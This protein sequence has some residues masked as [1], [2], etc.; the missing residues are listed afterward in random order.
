MTTS[1][2]TYRPPNFIIYLQNS[3]LQ[4]QTVSAS[5]LQTRNF[6]LKIVPWSKQYELT[7]LPW[8]TGTVAMKYYTITMFFKFCLQNVSP[9]SIFGAY[10]IKQMI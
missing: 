5:P 3:H 2:I 4:R 8:I 6:R 7:Q 9:L 1:D 10:R